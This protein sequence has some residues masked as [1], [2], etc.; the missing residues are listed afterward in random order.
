MLQKHTGLVG[1]TGCSQHPEH[2][3]RQ[4]GNE[5]QPIWPAGTVQL[6]AA[7][8]PMG[9]VAALFRSPRQ[10]LPH[11]AHHGRHSHEFEGSRNQTTCNL[12]DSP[13]WSTAGC[14]EGLLAHLLPPAAGQVAKPASLGVHLCRGCPL[15]WGLGTVP[16]QLALPDCMSHPCTQTPCN[17]AAMREP[18]SCRFLR[19][20]GQAHAL[21]QGGACT[22]GW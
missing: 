17:G 14:D 5:A 11:S 16:R 2:G 7:V 13:A 9:A 22:G 19:V 18:G 21:C 12:G 15:L 20:P 8:A 4:V 1:G 10:T 3:T 6:R